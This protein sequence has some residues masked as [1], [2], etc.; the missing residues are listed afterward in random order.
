MSIAASKSKVIESSE[1][2]EEKDAPTLLDLSNQKL[3]KPPENLPN[4][5]I[6]ILELHNNKIKSLSVIKFGCKYNYYDNLIELSLDHNEIE[7]LPAALFI[8]CNK[9]LQK[10]ALHDNHITTIPKEIE[11]MKNCLQ[12]LRLDRNKIKNLPNQICK[13]S[14]LIVLHIDGNPISSLPKDI[15]DLSSLKDL[16]IGSCKIEDDLPLSICK[17]DNLV[18]MWFEQDCFKNVPKDICCAGTQKILSHLK[19][20]LKEQ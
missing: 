8:Y 19:K 7:E 12:E 6:T 15:G 11:H 10:L 13:L 2:K 14:N 1:V 4:G 17:L 16:G 9:N 20:Q 5:D 18:I 3:I